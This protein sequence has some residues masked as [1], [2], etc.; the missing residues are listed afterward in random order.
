MEFKD[1]LKCAHVTTGGRTP[2]PDSLSNAEGPYLQAH[3]ADRGRHRAQP[4]RTTCFLTV[5]SA[6][7]GVHAIGSTKVRC[8]FMAMDVESWYIISI[9]VK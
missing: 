5:S 1:R 8:H 2:G 3:V 4:V 7:G 6:A 9:P